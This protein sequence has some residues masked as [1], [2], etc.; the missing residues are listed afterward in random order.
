MEP[1]QTP[2]L[3]CS[4]GPLGAGVWR[5][6]R[7]KGSRVLLSRKFHYSIDTD[8][9]PS[10]LSLVLYVSTFL[11]HLFF[12]S[13]FLCSSLMAAAGISSLSGRG[14]YCAIADGGKRSDIDIPVWAWGGGVSSLWSDTV[15]E[16]KNRVKCIAWKE[17]S[18]AFFWHTQDE[19][20]DIWYLWFKIELLAAVAVKIQQN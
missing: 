5:G 14:D 3:F 2:L 19:W 12:S 16:I 9:P 10:Q 4:C 17:R 15:S 13:R 18:S 6:W 20:V 8:L 1:H 7:I 11:S